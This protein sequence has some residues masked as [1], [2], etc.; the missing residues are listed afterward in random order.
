MNADGGCP[1]G[2]RLTRAR[3]TRATPERRVVCMVVGYWILAGIVAIAFVAAGLTKLT[4]PEAELREMG[5]LPAG[6]SLG[7][8]RGIGAVEVL[9][10]LG[11]ILPPVTGTAVI[12]APIAA[13]CLAI[14]MALAV[15][16]HRRRDEPFAVALGLGIMSIFAAVLGFMVWG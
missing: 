9:G 1:C 11:L 7:A 6:R 13:T 5:M 3:T 2:V 4:K 16:D 15:F 8:E 12:L 10:A 14:M